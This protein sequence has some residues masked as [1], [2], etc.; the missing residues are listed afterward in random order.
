MLAGTSVG[1][2]LITHEIQGAV[3]S[4]DGDF[5]SQFNLHREECYI[6]RLGQKLMISP[7]F[8]RLFDYTCTLITLLSSLSRFAHSPTFCKLVCQD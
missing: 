3:T 7:I 8:K 1:V 2:C 6:V 5:I 4:Q